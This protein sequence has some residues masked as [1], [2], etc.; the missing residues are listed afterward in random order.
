MMLNLS[1]N[2]AFACY[3]LSLL[4]GVLAWTLKTGAKR[5]FF[6]LPLAAGWI[7]NGLYL[8]LRWQ[9]SGRAPLA[10]QFESII[11]LVWGTIGFF[12]IFFYF[13]SLVPDSLLF[14]AGLFAVLGFGAAS[15]LDG[16]IEPLV[17]ALQSN[18]LVIHVITIMLG[19]AAL[20]LAF[21][22]ACIFL[23]KGSQMLE[24][25]SCKTIQIG[26]WFLTLGIITGSVWANSA[27][28]SYW[29]WDPKET[30]SLVTWIYYALVIHLRR[31]RGWKEK[32][33]AWLAAAG[34][35]FVLF[36]YFGVNYLLA[37][38]HSYA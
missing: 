33:F 35:V 32:R 27:W 14:P 22:A 19:Y 37:G 26:F 36:T 15:L 5:K 23:W 38:L 24:N 9:I 29:S 10:N 13:S 7:F 1:F 8:A 12:L 28:G 20:S 17:P 34:F 30:W 11:F 6:S 2:A 4:A 3:L 21:L 18:W 16:T 25:F 31:T